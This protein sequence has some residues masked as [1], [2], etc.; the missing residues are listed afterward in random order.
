MGF[1]YENQGS[2]NY[3]VYQVAKNDA[4][5]TT[6]LGMLSNNSIPGVADTL[7]VQMDN[8]KYIK[9]NVTA[10]VTLQSYF[11]GNVKKKQ[12][13]GVLYG[14]TE[15]LLGVEEYMIDMGSLLLDEDYIFVNV[16]KGDI[17]MICLPIENVTAK[18]DMISFFKEL[19]FHTQFDQTEN[20][21]HV[22]K[23]INYFNGISE[24]SAED[25][26]R[27]L[28][29]LDDSKKINEKIPTASS[30]PAMQA[31]A[32]QMPKNQPE[33]G[34]QVQE[35]QKER[36]S[37]TDAKGSLAGQMQKG[38]SQ[39]GDGKVGIA[40]P[41]SNG[42][43]NFEVPGTNGNAG[44]AVPNLQGS[45]ANLQ[46]SQ[47]AA[48]VGSPT[49][50]EDISLFYLLQHYNKDRAAQYKAQKAEKKMNK[51]MEKQAKKAA[52]KV[53][54]KGKKTKL[55]Q[56]GGNYA[57]PG[58]PQAGGNYAIPGQP[59]AGGN[60]AVPGQ[61]QVGGNYAIPGQ[62]QTGGNYAIPGQPQA[63]GNYAIPGQPQTGGNY[64]VQGQQ[65]TPGFSA[66]GQMQVPPIQTVKEMSNVGNYTAPSLAYTPPQ[67]EEMTVILDSGMMPGTTQQEAKGPY[68]VRLKTNERIPINT[69]IFKIGKQKGAVDYC[70]TDNRAV[71]RVHAVIL[72]RDGQYYITDTGSTNH[73]F[74]NGNVLMSNTE[75]S[76]T[77]GTKFS[78]A[79]EEF[80]FNIG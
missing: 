29:G 39:T 60:Y 41:Q 55:P 63:G 7:M 32:Y 42:K 10:R 77:P 56:A 67:E 5:D 35:V 78:L 48:T 76:L 20:G 30:K 16:A 21:E 24:F 33:T 73:T 79:N 14:I 12:L 2:T 74:V 1:T 59:Q 70:I 64:A 54:K 36:V 11:T 25:F 75:N 40:I 69:G 9:Y 53:G 34:M 28:R 37:G 72:Y 51:E 58:Q 15:A 6:A 71:S 43:E 27:F 17:V 46:Q 8:V 49:G 61:P 45:E 44:F 65:K 47:K 50:E 80:E 19:L 68:V 62:P 31:S 26:R 38:A 22:V 3:L 66:M 52:K 13:L 57:I 4:L 18:G 23:L